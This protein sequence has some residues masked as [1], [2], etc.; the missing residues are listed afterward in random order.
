MT[1]DVLVKISG[2]HAM[3]Q[4][5][6]QIEVITAGDYFLKNGK[7]Y[8][9]YEETVEGF[10]ENVRNTVKIS[11]DKMEI[12]KQGASMAQMVFEKDKKNLTRYVTPMGEMLVE[13]TTNQI[14]MKEEEDSLNVCVNYA[15]DINYQHVSDCKILMNISSREKA[16]LK[17]SES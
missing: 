1:K 12:R 5:S 15:L 4:D 11:E 17:L 6:D 8:V 2:L 9:I 16:E 3:E 10:E 7:H 13:I 14:E